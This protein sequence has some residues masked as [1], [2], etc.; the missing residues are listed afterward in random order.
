MVPELLFFQFSV[1]GP[2]APAS[3]KQLVKMGDSRVLAHR[4][5]GICICALLQVILFYRIT[6]QGG[7]VDMKTRQRASSLPGSVNQTLMLLP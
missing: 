4:I 5:P 1:S 3:Q 7:V 6:V 2:G